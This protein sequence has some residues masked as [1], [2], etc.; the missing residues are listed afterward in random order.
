MGQN[1]V[2][3]QQW[4]TKY[5]ILLWWV[6]FLPLLALIIVYNPNL[7]DI[8]SQ[9]IDDSFMSFQY[10]IFNSTVIIIVLR[11]AL[12][13]ISLVIIMICLFFPLFR[14]ST[15]GVQ[16][17]KE[18]EEELVKA[19]GEIAG[20]E[21]DNLI[22]DEVY[23]WALIHNWV[24]LKEPE[25]KDSHLLLRELLATLWEGFPNCKISLCRMNGKNYWGITH[26]LLTRLVL[27]EAI[28]ALDDERT[29]G[30]QLQTAGE[31][32]LLLRLYTGYPEGFSQIDE[33]F[34]LV[35]GE[36]YL[37]KVTKSGA[38]PEQLLAHFDQ[39]PLTAKT[40]EVYDERG[41]I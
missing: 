9:V 6:L 34:I 26:P 36:I 39:I 20:E 30:L 19:S 10:K 2:N 32:Y 11:I 1:I 17:T 33:K 28:M 22:Q 24:K 15:E 25:P 31:E 13:A 37:Q 4:L 8:P 12:V 40:A 3:L 7:F 14:V 5:R 41:V 35:L 38:T 21:I 16:W 29:Y 23:R 18:L 27:D